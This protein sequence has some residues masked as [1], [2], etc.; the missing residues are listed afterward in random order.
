MCNFNKHDDDTKAY[1]H[2]FMTK[3]SE[4]IGGVNFLL[5]LIEAMKQIKPNALIQ[6]DKKVV[7][8][9][10]KIEWNK[11]VFKDKFD[12]LNEIIISHKSSEGYDFNIL[13]EQNSKKAK[14]ILNMVKTLAPIEFVATAKDGDGFSFK[15]F[16]KL[17]DDYV[18]INPVFIAF[19]F[20]SAEFTKK[21]LKHVV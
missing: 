4:S 1:I 20:C 2:L 12:L 18:S 10:A 21:A 7:S 15:V 19:F 5:N 13:E 14:K 9:E 6:A 8:K 16:D 3:A 11:V 17:E